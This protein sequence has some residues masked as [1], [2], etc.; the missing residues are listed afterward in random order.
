M[1]G[2]VVP[3]IEKPRHDEIKQKVNKLIDIY[4]RG[5]KKTDLEEEIE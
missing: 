3:L 5:D 4:Y 2:S 1:N